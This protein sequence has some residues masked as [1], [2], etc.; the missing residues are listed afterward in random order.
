VIKQPEI[1][2]SGK[3]VP[4]TTSSMASA[5]GSTAPATS[6]GSSGG[7]L[8]GLEDFATHAINQAAFQLPEG[9]AKGTKAGKVVNSVLLGIPEAM[10]N[11]A[12]G[13][14]ALLDRL[15]KKSIAGT[16]GD[17][18][19][20]LVPGSAEA[21][22]G[23]TL[24]KAALTGAGEQLLRSAIVDDPNALQSAA[25]GGLGGGVG[26]K[27]GKSLSGVFGR[28][29][30]APEEAVADAANTA[31]KVYLANSI[32]D[33]STRDFK[34]WAQKGL[35]DAGSVSAPEKV[36]QEISD[37]YSAVREN[38][39]NN[40]VAQD[41]FR[42]AQP[43]RWAAVDKAVSESGIRLSDM[44]ND[45][46]K[47]PEVQQFN[48]V[49]KETGGRSEDLSD[50][51]N[52]ASGK[53]KA[54]DG[55]YEEG[56]PRSFYDTRATLNA[57]AEQAYKYAKNSVSKAGDYTP[58]Q[59]RSLAQALKAIDDAYF[60][61]ATGMV[62]PEIAKGM[63][64]DWATAKLLG[65]AASRGETSIGGFRLSSG[66]LTAARQ[67]P[68]GVAGLAVG[69]LAQGAANAASRPIARGISGMAADA[70]DNP[71]LANGVAR[72]G[73]RLGKAISP[74]MGAAAGSALAEGSEGNAT[75]PNNT[76]PGGPPIQS[77]FGASGQG[78][79][80]TPVGG[81]PNS[82][83]SQSYNMKYGYPNSTLDDAINQNVDKLFAMKFRNVY[84]GLPKQEAQAKERFRKA[85]LDG[86]HTKPGKAIDT[87]LAAR[88]LFPGQSVQQEQFSN[89]ANQNL[90]ITQLLHGNFQNGKAVGDGALDT[91]GPL[92]FVPRF[93]P[94]G[95][96]K[97]AN[98]DA[99]KAMIVKEAGSVGAGE[100]D[101]VMLNPLYSRDEKEKAIRAIFEKGPNAQGWQYY[102]QA[103]G[104]GQ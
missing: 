77:M 34:K 62:S 23:T 1:D 72:A 16:V 73:G 101:K 28:M 80:Y 17:V 74:S 30:S 11:A 71:A 37:I 70:L 58:E 3:I 39:L 2:S 44:G 15:A 20:L 79:N 21:K 104:G 25:L 90:A 67:N 47:L 9:V 33:L 29:S 38:G 54:G 22:L 42:K 92:G 35:G 65:L 27:L 19:G 6:T 51:I 69:Q 48:K 56:P 61:K 52:Q 68:L 97:T 82:Q 13:K 43:A 91:A 53:I 50:I 83:A 89:A 87:Q 96:Q 60:S 99:L 103:I 49:M 95:A 94:G 32:P 63:K 85:L 59:Q 78:N 14:Q 102:K 81:A 26:Y 24:G 41:A 18:A 75:P 31:K 88:V 8:D 5:S 66:S 36:R 55:T 98:Y 7:I 10:I 4:Q 40:K 100:F 76:H 57:Q 45:L 12:G 46:A 64:G 93:A 84:S 86:I